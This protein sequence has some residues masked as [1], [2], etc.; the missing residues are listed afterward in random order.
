MIDV[1]IFDLDGTLIDT[2]PVIITSFTYV[3]EKML[4]HVELSYEL[5]KTFIGPS[6]YDSFSRYTSD[7]EEI[8]ALINCYKEHNIPIQKDNVQAFKGVE[9]VLA[10]LKAKGYKLA[11]C[12]SKAMESAL[13]GLDVCDINKYFD[14]YIY[15]DDVTTPK[16][17]PEGINII[18][19]HFNTKK[20]IMVGDNIGDILA[21]NNAKIPSVGITYSHDKS[22]LSQANPSY[23]IDDITEIYDVLE[24]E[25][26]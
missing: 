20:A 25:N 4:P 7:E 11:I 6:L 19:N 14:Y 5:I 12:T 10:D 26:R 21:G 2:E 22:F 23:L 8:Q 17:D 15:L 13:V 18:L 9:S 24:K 16:P 3:F 1:I